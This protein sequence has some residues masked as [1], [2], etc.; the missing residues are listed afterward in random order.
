MKSIAL[1][2]AFFCCALLF[3]S[4]GLQAQ[5]GAREVYP[6]RSHAPSAKYF[7]TSYKLGSGDALSIRVFGEEDLSIEEIRLGGTGS[8]SYP[9]L[10]EI[11]VRGLTAIEVENLIT[12][13]L[14]GDYL[15]DPKVTVSIIEYRPFFVN[16]EVK[17]PGGYPF[18]PGLTLRKAIALAGGLT[19]RA[20]RNKFSVIR[21]DNP[22]R[23]PVRLKYESP[24]FPGDIV[25]IDESFF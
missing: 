9:F 21:D 24:I 7:E 18:K 23:V 11:R 20:S 6:S 16:G 4:S 19:E 8:F 5:P 25:T 12:R 2:I 22:S 10:G 3:V 17:N 15:I 13:G 14:T 1:K